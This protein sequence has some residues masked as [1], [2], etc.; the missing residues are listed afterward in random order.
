[1]DDKTAAPEWADLPTEARHPASRDL[2]R[3][4]TEEVVALLIEEDRRGLDAALRHRGEIARAAECPPTFGTD[5][6]RIR[7][8]MAGG[9]EA[10]F[11]A[12]EGA[13]DREDEG[14][15]AAEG[16][17]PG[18]LLIALSASSVTP[19]PRGA[20]I[21]ARERG[22]G[23]VLLTCAA[24]EGLAGLADLVLAL[25]TGPEIL[26]GSTRLKAGS[27]TKAALNAVTTA[28]MVRLGKVFENW[29]VDLRPGS[30]KLR[31][32]GVRIVAEAGGVP[33]ERAEEL[34]AAAGGEVK[35]ALVMARLGVG[36]EDARRRLAAAAG[37]V[38][39][40]LEG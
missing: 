40:A 11:A 12:R 7:A 20:L 23:T 21:A 3:L 28:A 27:A 35:T 6:E 16:L 29:M 38:R 8:A 14:R 32:R 26:T 15:R 13:E 5:P 10:V 9:A 18:D 30:A 37:S 2:D 39:R 4:A 22:A 19:F 1:M 33:R 36:A 25:E 24:Q 17:G 31:D 34:L